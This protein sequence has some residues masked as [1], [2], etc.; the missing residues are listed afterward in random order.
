[1][2]HH[3]M[4]LER[5]QAVKKRQESFPHSNAQER[6]WKKVDRRGNPPYYARQ[7]GSAFISAG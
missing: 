2:P 4:R 5:S 7:S 3:K 6:G 1:M